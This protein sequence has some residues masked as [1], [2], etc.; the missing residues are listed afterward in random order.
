MSPLVS[1]CVISQFKSEIF[2]KKFMQFYE[3]KFSVA[4]WA[5]LRREP[6]APAVCLYQNQLELSWKAKDAD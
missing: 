5:L 4:D 6:R 2:P 1:C 3:A